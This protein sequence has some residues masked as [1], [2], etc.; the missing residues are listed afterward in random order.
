M[1]KYQGVHPST[2]PLMETS[3]EQAIL[4]KVFGIYKMAKIAIECNVK[5]FV[6]ISTDKAVNL[7]NFM[8]ASKCLA[9]IIIQSI[10]PGTPSS[11]R[12]VSATSQVP[13]VPSSR[14]LRS[15]S[16]PAAW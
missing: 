8:G 14:S 6:R 12:C 3:S 10:R 11:W 16:R 15:R 4:N 1:E 7:T 13:T 9:E 2:F 5:R